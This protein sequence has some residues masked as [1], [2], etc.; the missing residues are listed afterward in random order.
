[1]A[2]PETKPTVTKPAISAVP[3]TPKRVHVRKPPFEL[4]VAKADAATESLAQIAASLHSWAGT[5]GPQFV[6][7]LSAG[8]LSATSAHR[9]AMAL[10]AT[11]VKLS[12]AKFTPPANFVVSRATIAVGDSVRLIPQFHERYAKV[13]PKAIAETLTVVLTDGNEGL[14]ARP[15]G[16]GDVYIRSWKHVERVTPSNTPA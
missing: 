12:D 10:M 8:H 7:V 1:M 5:S 2:K 14:A 9:A 6:D 3:A 15:N 13:W 16:Q 4:L 11:F